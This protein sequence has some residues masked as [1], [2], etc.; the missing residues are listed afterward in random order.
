MIELLNEEFETKYYSKLLM[1]LV[2]IMLESKKEKF[3]HI[4]EF[5]ICHLVTSINLI[6]MVLSLGNPKL[7]LY[8]FIK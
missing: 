5:L 7:F 3:N 6:G 4:T 2:I 1:K 8:M